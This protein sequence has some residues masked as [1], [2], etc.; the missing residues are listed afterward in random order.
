MTTYRDTEAWADGAIQALKDSSSA[1]QSFYSLLRNT[2]FTNITHLFDDRERRLPDEDYLTV[3]PGFIGAYPNAYLSVSTEDLAEFVARIK[4]LDGETDY[5]LLM[6]DY[7]IRRT[8]SSF[9][10]FSDAVQ[11]AARRDRRRPRRWP[12]NRPPRGSAAPEAGPACRL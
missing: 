7:G 6:D 8:N 4:A 10:Q 9:W 1:E 3:A 5:T 11:G 12:G 2:A